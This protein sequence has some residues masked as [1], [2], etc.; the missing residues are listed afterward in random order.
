MSAEP[1]SDE[2]LAGVFER[3][4]TGSMLDSTGVERLMLSARQ[5]R[6]ERDAA[7]ADAQSLADAVVKFDGCGPA[8]LD[9]VMAAAREHLVDKFDARAIEVICERR[10]TPVPAWDGCD[11]WSGSQEPDDG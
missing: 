4:T 3:Y 10:R 5:L 6:D 7:I 11:E 1:Y 2:E 9:A 8:L